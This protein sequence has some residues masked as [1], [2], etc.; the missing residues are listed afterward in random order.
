MSKRFVLAQLDVPLIVAPM[1]G[2]PWTP[3]LAAAITNGGGMG[4]IAGGLLPA[5]R[6]AE[7]IVA[8]RALTSGPLGVNLFVPQPTTGT[9]GRFAAYAKALAGEAE[10]YGVGLG[11]PH[12]S[13]DD[14]AAKLDLM[15]DLRPEVVSFTFG[16]PTIDEC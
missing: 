15:H 1:A 16:L 2:G 8:A 9:P 4:Y 12:H 10:H 13:D 7:Q 11:E 3:E 5:G 6:L 14:W